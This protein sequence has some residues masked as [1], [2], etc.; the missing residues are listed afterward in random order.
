VRL[1]VNTREIA[2][3][4]QFSIGLRVT[5]FRLA[6]LDVSSPEIAAVG[7]D[8]VQ[9]AIAV[10]VTNRHGSRKRSGAVA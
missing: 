1:A 4:K 8:Q 9:F 5:P 2:A 7:Y 6:W 10:E 3:Q